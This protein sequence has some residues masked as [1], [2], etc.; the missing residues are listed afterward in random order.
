MRPKKRILL[1]SNCEDLLAVR[2]FLFATRGFCVV[3]ATNVAEALQ[4]AAREALDVAVIELELEDGDGVL[5]GI[6]LIEML[7]SVNRELRTLLIS[8][9]AVSR[10]VAHLADRLLG[11]QTT[12]IDLIEACRLLA[13]R[14][15]RP[16]LPA[17]VR[18]ASARWRMREFKTKPAHLRANR[19]RARRYQAQGCCVTCGLPR[20]GRSKSRCRICLQ[21]L[22]ESVAEGRKRNAKANSR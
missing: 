4:A 17:P 6:Q 19:D 22:K 3:S 16:K 5:L 13:S 2:R 8:D 1:V 7:T 15:R 20:D 10:S 12:A 21:K 11:T 14:R 18:L 9:K